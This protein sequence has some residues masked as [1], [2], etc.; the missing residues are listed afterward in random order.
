MGQEVTILRGSLGLNTKDHPSELAENYLSKAVNVDISD[1]GA[2]SRRGGVSVIN[3]DYS[4]AH[5][6]GGF[7]NR[8]AVYADGVNLYCY[9]SST[10]ITT[11]IKSDLTSG[12]P[13]CYTPVG[14]ALVFSNGVERGL[15]V[16]GETGVECVSYFEFVAEEVNEEKREITEFPLVDLMHF[17]NGSMYGAAKGSSSLYGSE[18]YKP[19]QYDEEGGYV[20]LSAPINWIRSVEDALLVGTDAG[21]TAFTGHGIDDFQE[22]TILTF[23][24]ILCSDIVSVHL[25]SDSPIPMIQEGVLAL[26]DNGVMFISAQ[27]EVLDMTSKL[28]LDW[29]SVASGC[30]G[31]IDNNYVFS[32]GI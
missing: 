28:S 12:K 17:Y 9:D 16:V 24:S 11:T 23:P 4:D 1:K 3:G 13:L 14:E 8:Y 22:R 20:L 15:I 18:P 30:F 27:L 2:V 7:L 21:V 31:I 26:T 5:S 10:A 25:P 6:L 19:A 32:G 29:G